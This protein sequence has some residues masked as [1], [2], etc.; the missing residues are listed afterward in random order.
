MGVTAGKKEEIALLLLWSWHL[1]TLCLV[2]YFFFTDLTQCHYVAGALIDYTLRITVAGNDFLSNATA[3]P[4]R[5]CLN[6]RN[7]AY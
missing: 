2:S 1:A 3:V 6:R 5:C 4:A 7:I